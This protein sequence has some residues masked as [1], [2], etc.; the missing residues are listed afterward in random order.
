[1]VN[2]EQNNIETFVSLEP[3]QNLEEIVADEIKQW[4]ENSVKKVNFGAASWTHIHKSLDEICINVEGYNTPP[5]ARLSFDIEKL[6]S[7]TAEKLGRFIYGFIKKKYNF[8][9]ESEYLTYSTFERKTKKNDKVVPNEIDRLFSKND[10]SIKKD[11]ILNS[12]NALF[13]ILSALHKNGNCTV[14]TIKHDKRQVVYNLSIDDNGRL[15][16]ILTENYYSE[17]PYLNGFTLETLSFIKGSSSREIAANQAIA[18]LFLDSTNY[19]QFVTAYGNDVCSTIAENELVSYIN[20]MNSVFRGEDISNWFDNQGLLAQ[21][22]K[23]SNNS[24]INILLKSIYQFNPNNKMLS[25]DQLI[26]TLMTSSIEFNKALAVSMVEWDKI[27][28]GEDIN[29]MGKK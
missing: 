5:L 29:R 19:K 6:D 10:I 12:G 24:R 14:Y 22:V 1:M 26:G 9:D 18:Y 28:N 21:W 25:Y 2:N 27:R 3:G 15:K 17:D 8:R 13:D 16:V 20:D 23:G 7:D 4:V 11:Y